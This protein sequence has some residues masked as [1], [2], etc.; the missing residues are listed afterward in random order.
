VSVPCGAEAIT[1]KVAILPAAAVMFPG[2]V[3]IVGGDTTVNSAA[4]LVT[5][6]PLFETVTEK[7]A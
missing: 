4:E 1:E 3:A 7:L 6:P 2:C 5:C